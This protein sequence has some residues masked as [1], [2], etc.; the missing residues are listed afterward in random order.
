[1]S[2]FV[3]LRSFLVRFGTAAAL[4]IGSPS[5]VLAEDTSTFGQITNLLDRAGQAGFGQT[6]QSTAG[7]TPGGL[8]GRFVTVFLG[9]VGTIAFVVFLYGGY[10]WLT[11]RGDDDQ[12]AKAKQY[13]MNGT[14]GIIII[15]LAYSA[16]FFITSQ[17]YKSIGVR[18]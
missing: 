14:I 3:K 15:V 6:S 11:A 17:V 12:V 8:V 13:L 4:F 7:L 18:S 1:M 10:L 2:I 5:S 16:A 9:F